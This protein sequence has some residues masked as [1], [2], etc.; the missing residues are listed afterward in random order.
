MLGSCSVLMD[1]PD[2]MDFSKDISSKK[3]DMVIALKKTLA[4]LGAKAVPAKLM[5]LKH[6][7]LSVNNPIL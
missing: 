2:P 5:Q 4:I 6:T 3:S 7:P 1:E